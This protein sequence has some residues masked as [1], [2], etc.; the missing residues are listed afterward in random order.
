MADEKKRLIL[1][2]F[3][4]IL[5]SASLSSASWADI[6]INSPEAV[7][8]NLQIPWDIFFLPEGDILLTERPGKL[9]KISSDGNMISEAEVEGVYHT[10]E[11]G[12]HGGAPHPEFRENSLIYL[13]YTYSE[14]GEILN[15]VSRYRYNEGALE[16]EE[17][18]IDRIPGARIHNGGRIAFGPDGYLYIAT[19]DAAI[20]ELSQDRASLAGKILRITEN[21][22]IPSENPFGNEV[23]SYGHRNPQGLLWD[24]SGRLWSTEHGPRARDELNLIR[25]GKNYGW[26]RIT[27]DEAADDM[28]TPEVSS[29]TDYTWAPAGCVYFKGRVFFAGLKGSA[30][31]EYN[32]GTGELKTHFKGEYGRLRAVNVNNNYLYFTT[33]NRDGRGRVRPGDDKLFRVL[34]NNDP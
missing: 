19:G 16:N 12:L 34:M 23:Y 24:S 25:P 6:F 20:P 3:L 4:S 18:I 33:S 22:D 27:G 8:D 28:M 30:I 1:K 15:R 5:L 32:V 7:T 17:T 26:P 29:G 9:K 13:Y 11:G 2:L 14:S 21:G 10:G 31:Y